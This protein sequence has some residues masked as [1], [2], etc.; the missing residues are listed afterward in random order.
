[1]KTRLLLLA[2]GVVAASALLATSAA[3][4]GSTLHLTAKDNHTSFTVH[5]NEAIVVTLASC[6]DCGYSWKGGPSSV[7]KVVS[8][9][10]VQHTK[11]G[12]VGGTGKEIW[13]FKVVGPASEGKLRLRYVSPAGHIAKHFVVSLRIS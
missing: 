13:R 1:M 7:V 6:P 10:Y 12:Q 11:P 8:H 4:A 2:T 5:M 3:I 9:R